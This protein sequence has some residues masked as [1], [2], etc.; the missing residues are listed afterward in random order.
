MALCGSCGIEHHTSR[1]LRG[2]SPTGVLSDKH[3]D[4]GSSCGPYS[5]YELAIVPMGHVWEPLENTI[6]DIHPQ[7]RKPLWKFRFPVEKFQ[8]TAGAKNTTFGALEKT[9][10]II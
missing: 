3:T 6:L 2:V 5:G 1:D 8:Y 9:T 10:G 4:L 7:M